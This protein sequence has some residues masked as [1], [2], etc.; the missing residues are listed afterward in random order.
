M[1]QM[2]TAAPSVQTSEAAD[3]KKIERGQI[4]LQHE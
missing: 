3:N 2:N 1:V 4:L